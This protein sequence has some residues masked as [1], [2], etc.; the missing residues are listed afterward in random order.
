MLL[1]FYHYGLKNSA[2][3]SNNLIFNKRL[4]LTNS[5]K[6]EDFSLVDF[7]N[8]INE[9]TSIDFSLKFTENSKIKDFN[10]KNR[11]LKS[12]LN[13]ICDIFKLEYYYD[14]GN[15]IIIIDNKKKYSKIYFLNF[16]FEDNLNLLPA[17]EVNGQTKHNDQNNI[18]NRFWTS[19]KN[20]LDFLVPSD[21]SL[22]SYNG[23]LII[24]TFKEKHSII[25]SYIDEIKE[26]I[27]HSIIIECKIIE[28][29]TDYNDLFDLSSILSPLNNLITNNIS[30]IVTSILD[31]CSKGANFKHKISINISNDFKISLINQQTGYIASAN[32]N[33]YETYEKKIGTFN[34][35]LFTGFK[36][37]SCGV[38]MSVVPSI[39][40]DS[41]V[42]LKIRTHISSFEKKNSS[43][44]RE[45]ISI[46]KS[47]FNNVVI[48]G[49]LQSE[50]IFDNSK[51]KMKLNWFQRLFFKDNI[52]RKKSHFIIL[53]KT[54]Y[55]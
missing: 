50:Q 10:Y 9:K 15:K 16:F 36:A 34:M 19:I 8:L 26:K 7:F 29:M 6:Y 4:S 20:I 31:I 45:M 32:S 17:L 23:L 49:G 44:N 18:N 30:S 25:K 40:N 48:L 11:T 5:E 1:F 54:Y 14:E 3:N 35:N 38:S 22:D 33:Y 27:S 2:E 24:N 55:E 28:I 47:K 42:L 52:I 43:Y 46:V 21:Y 12:I 39:I 51:E 37:L 41:Q 13:E 53:I